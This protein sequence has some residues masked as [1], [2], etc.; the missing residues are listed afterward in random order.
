MASKGLNMYM[1]ARDPI[2][3]TNLAG[4]KEMPNR[5]MKNCPIA[6]FAYRWPNRIDFGY[7]KERL[8]RYETKGMTGCV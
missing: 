3:R 1:K 6:F 5:Y 4:A 8:K 2:G 7:G